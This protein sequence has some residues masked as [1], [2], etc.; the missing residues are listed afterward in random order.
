MMD[1]ICT[2]CNIPKNLNEFHKSKVGRLGLDSHC[3]ECRKEYSYLYVRKNRS[4]RAEYSRKKYN[5]DL[6]YRISNILR[7]KFNSLLK[8]KKS[9]SV[10]KLLGCSIEDYKK[11]IESQ[12][13][14][15]YN[16]GN[17][18]IIWEIDHI[19]PIS[20]FN[21]SDF[22]QQKKCFHYSNLSPKFITTK[23]S[24]QFGY[25]DQIGNRNKYNKIK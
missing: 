9:L 24:E 17:Y 19:I 3:K 8:D 20:S 6:N 12:F 18:G 23:I 21:L 22:E 13:L 1:K 14:P 7:V 16:W 11:H 25:K 4:K 2:K 15:E 10:I 5:E